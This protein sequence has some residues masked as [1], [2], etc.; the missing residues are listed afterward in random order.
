MCLC[1]RLCVTLLF[2]PGGQTICLSPG[3]KHFLHTE[4]GG[5][6]ISHTQEGGGTNIFHT[7]EGGQTFF[8]HRGGTN[9][10]VGGGGSYDDE[11]EEIDVSEANIFVSEASKLSAGARIFRG[12]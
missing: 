4:E 10:F 12:P 3:D 11:D 5:T 6:N 1:V 2:V 8:T 7:Q 9:I